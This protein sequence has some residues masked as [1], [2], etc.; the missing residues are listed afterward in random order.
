MAGLPKGKDTTSKT[1]GKNK[2]TLNI[3]VGGGKGTG[4]TE[5]PPKKRN[6]KDPFKSGSCK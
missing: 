2:G 4:N 6:S 5:T 3:P 1:G